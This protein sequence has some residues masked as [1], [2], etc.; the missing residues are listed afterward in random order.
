MN[1]SSERRSTSC[2]PRNVSPPKLRRTHSSNDLTVAL[3]LIG[4]G[5]KSDHNAYKSG[6]T[7]ALSSGMG[8][9]ISGAQK[10]DST[11]SRPRHARKFSLQKRKKSIA[12]I[13]EGRPGLRGKRARSSESIDRGRQGVGSYS[14]WNGPNTRLLQ[15]RRSFYLPPI[16]AP[17]VVT[18]SASLVE[19]QNSAQVDPVAG[20]TLSLPLSPGTIPRSPSTIGLLEA[21]DAVPDGYK[22]LGSISAVVSP[23]TLHADDPAAMFLEQ[24][25]KLDRRLR[26]CV[27]Y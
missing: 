13:M 6:P 24:A 26:R 20:A 3:H 17:A 22:S 11:N 1:D 15:P 7:T 18:S 19:A 16:A 23:T 14:R 4:L 25:Q 8:S 2:P 12:P 21:E 9:L 10:R 27:S 5:D